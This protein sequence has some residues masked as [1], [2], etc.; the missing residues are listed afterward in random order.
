MKNF[1][2]ILILPNYLLFLIISNPNIF[3]SSYTRNNKYPIGIDDLI[4]KSEETDYFIA[5]M[6]WSGIFWLIND[7]KHFI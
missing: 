1:K 6:L 3:N 7:F 2:R 5:V 4:E